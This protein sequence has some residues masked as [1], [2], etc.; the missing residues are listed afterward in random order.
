MFANF[1]SFT[2]KYPKSLKMNKSKS[3]INFHNF[4]KHEDNIFITI[5]QFFGGKRRRRRR[6]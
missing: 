1:S 4:L 6:S 5:F 3:Y 2:M